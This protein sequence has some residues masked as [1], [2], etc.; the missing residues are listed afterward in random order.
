[1]YNCIYQAYINY[2]YIYSYLEN[3]E[4]CRLRR[5]RLLVAMISM[6]NSNSRAPRNSSFTGRINSYRCNSYLDKATA[7]LPATVIQAGLTA[8]DV[9]VT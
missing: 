1:M 7:E 8:K 9:T 4:E 6:D 3:L 5:K 2:L